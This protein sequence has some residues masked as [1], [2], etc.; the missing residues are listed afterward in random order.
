MIEEQ[1]RN[2]WSSR[3]GGGRDHA[4]LETSLIQYTPVI[5]SS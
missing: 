2:Y 1:E 3:G 4:P 5:Q